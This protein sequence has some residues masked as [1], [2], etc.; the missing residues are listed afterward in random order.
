MKKQI[1]RIP[2]PINPSVLILLLVAVKAQH[3]KQGKNSPLGALDWEKFGPL[4]DEASQADTKLT[5]CEKEVEKLSG[6]RK[7][8]LD[9]SLTDFARS[10]RDMLTGVFRGDLKQMVDFGFE[11][12]DTPRAKKKSPDEA[13]KK[14]A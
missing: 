11:V 8:L 5:Q 3:E 14:S 10:C 12:D 4:V 1:A 6:R 13:Q 7:A 2:M 9:D